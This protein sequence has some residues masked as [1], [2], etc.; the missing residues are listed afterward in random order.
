MK[1]KVLKVSM[2]CLIVLI[3]GCAP[4][5]ACKEKIPGAK[6]ISLSETYTQEV[7]GERPE[8]D[9]TKKSIKQA[10]NLNFENHKKPN[11]AL[12]VENHSKTKPAIGDISD[13]EDKIPILKPPRIA[14]IWISP[15]I[16]SNGDL[17]MESF[18][19]TEIEGKKWVIGDE[20]PGTTKE[21]LER[22]Y[23][24]LK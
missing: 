20:I 18:I 10:G 11:V 19:Y 5:Y 17:L 15:W 6:C 4:R 13:H 12:V 7:L 21:N 16:D 2:L 24:P 8:D 22:T 3:T 14:R 1:K 9:K 23:N